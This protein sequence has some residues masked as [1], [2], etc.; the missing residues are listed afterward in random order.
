MTI[1]QRAKLT[2]SDFGKPVFADGEAKKSMG[3]II[4]KISGFTLRADLKD[5]T[6]K[7]EGLTGM[8]RFTPDNKEK[9]PAESGIMFLPDAFHNLLA[10]QYRAAAKDDAGA[11]LEFG[12]VVTAFAAKNPAGY[13]WQMT[14]AFEN[15][16]NPLQVLQDNVM[17]AI[18]GGVGKVSSITDQTAKQP[19]TAAKR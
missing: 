7:Y 2:L 18:A 17:K 1:A 11:V 8:F 12:L 5:P 4:G 13:S 14:P 3:M 6:V 16:N 10:D 15:K 19:A 9:D